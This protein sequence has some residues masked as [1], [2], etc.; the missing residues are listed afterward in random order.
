MKMKPTLVIT[1]ERSGTHLLIN[2]INYENKGDFITIGYM[3]KIPNKIYTIDDFKHETYKHIMSYIYIDG[4]NVFKSH[5]QVEFMES[6]LDFIFSNYNVIYLK[7]DVKDVLWSYYNF[8]YDKNTKDIPLFEDWIFMTPNEIGQKL[9]TSQELHIM[10]T[11]PHIIIEPDNFVE[12][13][14]IHVNGWMKYKEKMLVLNYEDLLTDFENQKLI[15]EKFIDKKIADKIPDINDKELPNFNPG[16][17]IIGEHKNHMSQETID[18]I[19]SM[20]K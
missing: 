10:G 20:I 19:N 13:W 18:K 3:K 11:D 9:L 12:R 8:L 2:I 7:R 5:H 6:Y 17:G 4:Y 16:K 15:I 14:K 1:H